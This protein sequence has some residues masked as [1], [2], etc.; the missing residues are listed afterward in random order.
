M[1]DVAVDANV[2]SM[3]TAEDILASLRR[4]PLPER[5]LLIGLAAQ[6]AAAE[7]PK[8]PAVVRGAGHTSV[9]SVDD[10]VA[11]RLSLLPDADSVSL[12]DMERAIAEGASG[13]AGI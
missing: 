3:A 11:A 5:L 7:T 4:L 12:A 13:R 9:L 1:P 10:L 8:P 6:E 2:G